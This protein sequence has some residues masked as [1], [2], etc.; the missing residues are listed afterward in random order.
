MALPTQAVDPYRDFRIPMHTS[1]PFFLTEGT[2]PK[3]RYP[4]VPPDSNRNLEIVGKLTSLQDLGLQNCGI[5]DISFLSTLT[6]LRGI[7]L[8]H[9]LISSAI[10]VQ[11]PF[12]IVNTCIFRNIR[13]LFFDPCFGIFCFLFYRFVT[14]PGKQ[15]HFGDKKSDEIYDDTRRL[16]VLIQQKDGSMQEINEVPYVNG[17]DAG[18]MRGDLPALLPPPSFSIR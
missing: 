15:W 17:K 18:G 11:I 9:N 6:E 10:P 12:H 2:D 4:K 14:L 16:Y 3:C 8:N 7:N 5:Q 13:M 1:V